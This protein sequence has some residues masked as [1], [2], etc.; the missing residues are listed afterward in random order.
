MLTI[1]L[2]YSKSIINRLLIRAAVNDEL[3]LYVFLEQTH[4]QVAR[5]NYI[6][7]R[8]LKQAG[9]PAKSNSI[10]AKQPCT[11]DVEDCGT[12]LRFLTAYFALRQGTNILLTGTPRLQERPIGPLVNALR[13]LGAD[14]TCTNKEGYP[15]LLIRGTHL[16]GKTVTL[17]ENGSSQYV[18]AILLC[19]DMAEG[20]VN[21]DTDLSRGYIS[22]TLQTIL[23]SNTMPKSDILSQIEA[24][25]SAAA[26][27][28]EYVALHDTEPL[29]LKG[30]RQ[31]SPQPDSKTAEM[32]S[33]LG[34]T[35]TYQDEGVIISKNSINP[36]VRENGISLD[37]RQTP[38]LYPALYATCQR[39][40]IPLKVINKD[41]LREKESNRIAAM[42]AMDSAP[43]VA[44]CNDHRIAM[45]M[46]V[47]GQQVDN[48]DCIH[49]S[50]PDFPNQYRKLQNV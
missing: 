19:S 21:I 49:K 17:P 42:E 16:Q 48:T 13:Q 14:I 40:N 44:S 50:F 31:N 36:Q 2:P 27:F 1:D 23:L 30:L 7:Y 45:A 34:V 6:L 26:F 15:P 24:D 10:Q 28:Y 18:S 9:C 38:D 25:W 39:L 8:A 43:V 35:T 4:P 29:W 46:L 47:A 11:V 12:A 3:H 41:L 20:R 5:D 37:C 33:Q 22:L 32:F